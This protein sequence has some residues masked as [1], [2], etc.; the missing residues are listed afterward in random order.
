MVI[1]KTQVT[2]IQYSASKVLVN[3]VITIG[4]TKWNFL[5]SPT[6]FKEI[7]DFSQLGIMFELD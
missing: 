3:K 2:Q 7:I 6:K 1:V 4:D 5:S